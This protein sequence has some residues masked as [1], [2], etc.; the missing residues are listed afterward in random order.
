M[1]GW[2]RTLRA[3]VGTVLS[4]RYPMLLLWGEE[5]TQLYND[6]YSALIGDKHPAAM[7]GDVRVTLAEGW[8][9]LGPIIDEAMRTGVASWVPGLRLLLERAGYREEAYFTVS[10][11][12]A[13]DDEGRTV[14]VLTVCSEV[15]D[16]V[17]GQ[18]RLALLREVSARGTR[19]AGVAEV[20]ADL[21]GV[22]RA[23]HLDVPFAE[24]Y[25]ARG[26][27]ARRSGAATGRRRADGGRPVGG[28]ARRGTGARPGRVRPRRGAWRT[29]AP[30][31]PALVTDV[32]ARSTATG[33][34]FG[35]PVTTAVAV[36]LASAD[37]AHPLGVLLLGVN[38]AKALDE[39]HRAFLELLAQQVATSL[40]DARAYAEEVARA[41]ALAELDR[42]KT[43]F[44]TGV[45]H[46]FRT[47]LTLMLGPLQD[48]LDDPAASPC[49]RP[50]GSGSGPPGAT[51]GACSPWSTTC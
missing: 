2:P 18:R 35:D 42:V 5:L 33:G 34:P 30:G 10:H 13:R 11:G 41:E 31:R 50:S 29:R 26:R 14:G 19:T 4:S 43:E 37:P 24:L 39:D 8:D 21:L 32:A 16:E 25:L 38:P 49:R 27:R 6:A 23:G 40:R 45:S 7:G 51:P 46:E 36:P 28:G 3:A 9:V 17:V 48:A 44:F 20:A 15:T 1:E 12:P 47:P 22:L